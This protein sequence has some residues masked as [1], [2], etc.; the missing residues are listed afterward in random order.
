MKCYI[1]E[2]NANKKIYVS[3]LGKIS[4]LFKYAA[5]IE[6]LYCVKLIVQK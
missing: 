3:L 5:N 6:R 1:S 2:F 4:V